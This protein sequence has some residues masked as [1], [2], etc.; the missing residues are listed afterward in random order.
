MGYGVQGSFGVGKVNESGEALLS[1]CANIQLCVM[2]NMFEK[3]RIQQHT[4]QHPGTKHWH[5]ID[6][7]LMHQSHT[8]VVQMS[9]CFD[10]HSVGLIVYYI[11]IYSCCQ[12]EVIM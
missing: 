6:Y 4:W 1:F 5:C 8:I 9:M 2:N 10:L 7:V 3:R 11:E 12:K